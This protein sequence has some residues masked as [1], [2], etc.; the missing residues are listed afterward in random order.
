MNVKICLKEILDKEDRSIA[1]LSRQTNISSNSLCK[2]YN[3]AAKQLKLDTISSICKTLNIDISD[4]L[5][6]EE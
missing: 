1:W 6:L 5:K 4:L 3:N 2:I